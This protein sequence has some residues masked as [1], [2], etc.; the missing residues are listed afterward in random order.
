MIYDPVG[1]DM[2]EQALRAIAWNGRFLVIGF[3]AGTIPKIPL[4]LTLL[5]GCQIVGVFWGDH[6][7]K[8]TR[9]KHHQ[10]G[11]FSQSYARTGPYSPRVFPNKTSKKKP[12]KPWMRL[13][14]EKV[15][16]KVILSVL[17]VEN[18]FLYLLKRQ[19]P[20]GGASARHMK[21]VLT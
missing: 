18:S 4:N 19:H 7:E 11:H 13:Q 3:A 21:S 14:T 17:K 10:H 5:K 6:V 16:G 2:S 15:M 9:K 8:R 1:G 12:S 20:A